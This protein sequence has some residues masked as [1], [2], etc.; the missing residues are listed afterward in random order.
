MELVTQHALTSPASITV[1]EGFDFVSLVKELVA[2]KNSTLAGML[3]DLLT[4][5]EDALLERSNVLPNYLL[6]RTLCMPLFRQD[7]AFDPTQL[8]GPFFLVLS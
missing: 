6:N 4:P 3:L 8:H 2:P 1:T 7:V 5:Y